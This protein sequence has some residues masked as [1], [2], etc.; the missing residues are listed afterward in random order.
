MTLKLGKLEEKYIAMY[1]QQKSIKNDLS[2]YRQFVN[3]MLGLP[4]LKDVEESKNRLDE[5]WGAGDK[6]IISDL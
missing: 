3:E 1:K 4:A 6:E 2:V 5:A